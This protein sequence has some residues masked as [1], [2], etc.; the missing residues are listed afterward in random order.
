MAGLNNGSGAAVKRIIGTKLQRKQKK[1]SRSFRAVWAA[2]WVAGELS[3]THGSPR[4]A[5]S[6]FDVPMGDVR[7]YLRATP[8]EREAIKRKRLT[9]E[10]LRRQQRRNHRPS[11]AGIDR[12]IERAGARGRVEAAKTLGVSAGFLKTA[13]KLKRAE[14][15]LDN[16]G[17]QGKRYE[18]PTIEPWPSAADGAQLLDEITG[19]IRK[20]VVM[21]PH[22]AEAIALWVVHTHM[23]DRFLISPRLALRSVTKQ[24]GKDHD[25]RYHRPLGTAAAADRERHPGGDVSDHRK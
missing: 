2:E 17:R 23:F 21:P 20:Y 7:A 13:R 14:L 9:I 8:L 16:G 1:I 22:A 19:T 25:A 5:A 24:C 18:F 15:G 3:L 12:F 11:E 4:Q 10:A 6:T